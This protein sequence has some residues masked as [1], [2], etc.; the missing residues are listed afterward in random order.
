MI[1]T[2]DPKTSSKSS[3]LSNKSIG[4]KFFL[5]I[6][7]TSTPPKFS[8]F[9]CIDSNMDYNLV[10]G[11]LGYATSL[12]VL[13]WL[14]TPFLV[15]FGHA[16]DLEAIY[17]LGAYPLPVFLIKVA[18]PQIYIPTM[19]KH[20]MEP[21]TKSGKLPPMDQECPEANDPSKSMELDQPVE[22]G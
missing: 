7:C 6:L 18:K 3:G 12:G 22:G 9:G 4:L 8:H 5:A 15:A 21:S 13:S 2:S 19:G 16:S 17:N 1:T 20:R 11:W 14:S 10:L